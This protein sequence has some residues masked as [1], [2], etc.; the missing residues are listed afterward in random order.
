MHLIID[1]ILFLSHSFV[2]QID[3][4]F[5]LIRELKELNKNKGNF[6]DLLNISHVIKKWQSLVLGFSLGLSKL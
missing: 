2:I 5:T 4:L 3:I 1:D 6:P